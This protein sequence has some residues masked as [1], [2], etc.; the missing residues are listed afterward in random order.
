[1]PSVNQPR[2]LRIVV[3]FRSKVFE[4][5]GPQPTV[6]QPWRG[7]AMAIAE[8]AKSIEDAR[9]VRQPGALV[10]SVDSGK[11]FAFGRQSD[12]RDVGNHEFE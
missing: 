7:L 1:M 2:A 8:G 12:V 3:D 9:L 11:G 6:E 5:H 4:P 10:T